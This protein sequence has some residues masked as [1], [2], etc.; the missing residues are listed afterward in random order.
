MVVMSRRCSKAA[1]VRGRMRVV[2]IKSRLTR[3]VKRSCDAFMQ[4][5]GGGS[6]VS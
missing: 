1:E 5:Q 4:L 2:G 6:S 3:T